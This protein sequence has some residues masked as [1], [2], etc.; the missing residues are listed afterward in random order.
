MKDKQIIAANDDVASHPTI[1]TGRLLRRQTTICELKE[2]DQNGTD[3]NDN[4][5]APHPPF[6]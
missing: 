5:I 6:P 4:S 1:A 2:G 3:N